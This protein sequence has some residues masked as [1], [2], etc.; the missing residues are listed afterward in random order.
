[1]SIFCVHSLHLRYT[2]LECRFE[3]II[4]RDL[5]CTSW[6]RAHGMHNNYWWRRQAYKN[7]E[8]SERAKSPT[9][10]MK[11]CGWRSRGKKIRTESGATDSILRYKLIN[12]WTD[13][14]KRETIFNVSRRNN[15]MM[16]SGRVVCLH[17]CNKMRG[18]PS[19]DCVFIYFFNI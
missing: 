1:M 19:V 3:S 4:S 18:R 7:S 17:R 10:I 13:D 2:A 14:R 16:C 5:F 8:E 9:Q 6:T 15:S 11:M 12:W